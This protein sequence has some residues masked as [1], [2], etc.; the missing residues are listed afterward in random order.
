MSDHLRRMKK[1]LNK[2]DEKITKLS[3]FINEEDGKYQTLCE[4]DQD[5]LIAQASSMYTYSTI[6]GLRLDLGHGK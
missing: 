1:E 6:L 3:A 5:L 2:L 4:F